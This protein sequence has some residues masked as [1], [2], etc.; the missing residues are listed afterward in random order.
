MAKEIHAVT[1]AF[2]YSGKYIAQ[3]L[4]K[5]GCTV[6]TLTNSLSRLNPFGDAIQAFPFDFDNPDK[7]VKKL[8]GIQVL[9]NT[10]WV[11]FNHK[12]FTFTQA[13]ENT[14]R[15]FRAAKMAGVQRIVHI[16]ITNPS[17]DSPFEY[18]R[19]KAEL[20]K[21]LIDS[22]L[23]YAIIRPAV[24]FGRE[25]ILINNIAWML[26]MFPVFGVFG[27]G[28]YKL[29]PIDVRDLADLC[30]GQ[31]ALRQNCIINAIGPETFT[32]KELVQITAA[33]IGVKRLIIPTPA[34]VG[35]LVSKIISLC[36]G[37]VMITLD[38]M[39]ALMSNLLYVDSPPT[40]HT[41]LTDWIRQHKDSLGK[42]YTSELSRRQDRKK[43]YK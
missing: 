16:S 43:A 28:G 3:E 18:F 11:R 2:G 21:I 13:I 14:R 8:Q 9:Y 15:L 24:I 10:Y 36:V 5:R 31:G 33:I 4:I 39:K 35:L 41:K 25:D 19:G 17:E 6:I 7:L 38:E 23:S 42:T 1:G 12:T 37:D 30:V 20:E 26:R 40:G 22:G 29:R 32:F 34:V 27:D